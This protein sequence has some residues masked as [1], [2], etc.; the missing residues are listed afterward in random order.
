MSIGQVLAKQ[1]LKEMYSG[2][3][4]SVQDQCRI[5][6]SYDKSIINKCDD[7][8]ERLIA[9]ATRDAYSATS[10]AYSA[11]GVLCSGLTHIRDGLS[12]PIG[13]ELAV[14]AKGAIWNKSIASVQDQCRVGL[15]FLKAEKN[16]GNS[17]E[18]VVAATAL[19]AYGSLGDAYSSVGVLKASFN[20][21]ASGVGGSLG[22]VLAHVGVA[23]MYNDSV[24]SVQDQ[25]RV[26]LAYTRAVRDNS[27]DG[28]QKVLAEAALDSYGRVSDAY[29]GG[30][31]LG[32]FLKGVN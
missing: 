20:A 7:E 5:G 4:S 19:T 18:A 23:S 10:D 12:E 28:E 9:E 26:G 2:S 8:K 25:C 14:V 22:A 32:D 3:V 13:K 21:L 16:H 29:A 31:I 6:L 1:G 30:R 11:V 17:A 15:S 27:S 24:A